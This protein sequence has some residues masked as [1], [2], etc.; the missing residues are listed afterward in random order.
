[1]KNRLSDLNDHLF[2]QI[3]RLSEEDLTAEQ[4]E[5]EVKRSDAIVQVADAI[6]DNARLQLQACKLIADHGDRF[7][8]RLPM[9]GGPESEPAK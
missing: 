6:V 8:K 7:E 5:G 1:M 4:I 2:A 9:L 3:E